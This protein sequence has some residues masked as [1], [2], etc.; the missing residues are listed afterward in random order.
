MTFLR[1]ARPPWFT[2]GQQQD[3]SEFLKFLIDQLHEQEVSDLK[4]ELEG[5]LDNRDRDGDVRMAT[6][7]DRCDDDFE[8]TVG[9]HFGGKMVT[10]YTC[11]HC[12]NESSRMEHF[13]DIPLA[14]PDTQSSVDGMTLAGGQNQELASVTKMGDG[15]PVA[16]LP[17]TDLSSASSSPNADKSSPIAAP[18]SPKSA[19]SSPTTDTKSSPTT[20][21]SKSAESK[22]LHLSDLLQYYLQ[23]E[24]L[25]G[26][27]KYHCDQ[28]GGLRDGERKIKVLKAPDHLI[29]TLLRFSY[30]VKLQ[31]RSKTFQEVKYPRTLILPVEASP[32]SSKEGVN[33]KRKSLRSAVTGQIARCGVNVNTKR[34]EV[35]GLG[36]VVVHSGTSSDCGHYYSY[37]RHSIFCDPDTICDSLDHCK[38][39]DDIDFLQDKWYLFND[40]RISY[41]SY[42]SFCD[43]TQRFTKDT[44]YVLVYKRIDIKNAEK[45][46]R[47]MNNTFQAKDVDPPL[48]A[49]LRTA[50][51]RDNSLFLQV[52]LNL[53]KVIMPYI[54]VY[55]TKLRL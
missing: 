41:A 16:S 5:N 17:H 52:I 38:S 54:Y 51:S 50:L 13:T 42:R 28:C 20:A 48:R 53:F 27:N 30:N 47:N 33:V 10:T 44:A 46:E 37:A 15:S 55:I 32:V 3:C 8:T 14:F 26:D 22:P 49:D 29:L 1:A 23:P 11:L 35:Y 21:K 45:Q 24:K 40:N 34:G 36:G 43:V 31:S 39:E 18:L 2:A 7:K 12:M 19:K 6:H 9:E 4:K 25:T